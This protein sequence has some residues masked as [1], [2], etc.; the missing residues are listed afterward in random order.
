[1]RIHGV[2][3]A[4]QR[5]NDSQANFHLQRAGRYEGTRSKPVAGK[6]LGI[7][8]VELSSGSVKKLT[9]DMAYYAAPVWSPNGKWMAYLTN[10]GSGDEERDVFVM[11]SDGTQA[12]RFTKNPSKNELRRS[13][14]VRLTSNEKGD[15]D[16][17]YSPDG[18]KIVF[19]P[20]RGSHQEIYTM[21]A[22][23]S[24]QTRLASEK[25]WSNSSQWSPYSK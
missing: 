14:A 25:G 11:P 12:K 2:A 8:D 7:Y 24:N 15:A 18:C 23:G 3:L 1:M 21:N 9:N 20:N 13:D 6:E 17:D 22:D 10:T 19:T 16:P 4:A 5:D